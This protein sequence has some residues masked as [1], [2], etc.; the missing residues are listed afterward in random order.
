VYQMKIFLE[1]F[2]SFQDFKIHKFIQ[3][4]FF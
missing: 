1:T 3:L 2:D 4:E